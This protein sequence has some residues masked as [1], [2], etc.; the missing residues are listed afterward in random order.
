MEVIMYCYTC[1]GIANHSEAACQGNPDEYTIDP[2]DWLPEEVLDELDSI[3]ASVY[4]IVPE[5]LIA[6][7]R[8][9]TN[10]SDDR[11]HWEQYD[12]MPWNG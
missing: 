3:D 4:D 9:I 11:S 8:G 2:E 7:L 5:E 12:E 6:R 1:G 10:T